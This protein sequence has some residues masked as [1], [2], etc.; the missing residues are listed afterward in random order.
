[1]Q[2]AT[3]FNV[4]RYYGWVT[5]TEDAVKAIQLDLSDKRRFVSLDSAVTLKKEKSI[6]KSIQKEKK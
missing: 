2:E 5:T 6:R 3:L 1:M 4:K